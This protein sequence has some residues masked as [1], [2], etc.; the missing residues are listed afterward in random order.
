MDI[1]FTIETAF[2]SQS[3]PK[4]AHIFILIDFYHKLC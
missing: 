3:L 4:A 1:S 2:K